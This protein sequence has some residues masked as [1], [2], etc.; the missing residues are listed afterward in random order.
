MPNGYFSAGGWSR[1]N[2]EQLGLFGALPCD[3]APRNTQDPSGYSSLSLAQ[4][5]RIVGIDFRTATIR[6]PVEA[7]PEARIARTW[8]G[9][10]LIWAASQL[11]AAP[12][13]GL[14]TSLL[15]ATAPCEILTLVG[16]GT[17][18]R[19]S[20]WLKAAL[21]L[22]LSAAGVRSIRRPT[23]CRWPAFSWI[24]E[25]EETSFSHAHRWSCGPAMLHHN[26]SERA[27]APSRIPRLGDLVRACTAHKPS[28]HN[29]EVTGERF[30]ER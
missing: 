6:I 28:S 27:K 8:D 10:V 21:D 15:M 9:N 7:V 20:D 5:K 23:E 17:T 13:V 18:V 14:K 16:P 22:L 24:N 11:V 12:E 2:R 19:D 4:S 25:R 30:H 1:S 29:T 3:L 26:R